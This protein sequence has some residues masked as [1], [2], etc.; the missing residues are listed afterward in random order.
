MLRALDRAVGAHV[1][2]ASP[3]L[4]PLLFGTV[5]TLT[6][7]GL[8]GSAKA[9][10]PQSCP[11]YSKC[12]EVSYARVEA[13]D[14]DAARVRQE[15]ATQEAQGLAQ[16]RKPGLTT[17]QQSEILG[18]LIIHDTSLSPFGN[19]ACA[20]CH[21]LETGFTGGISIFNQENVAYPGS[22]VYRSGPRKPMSYA[23]A[24]FAPLLHYDPAAQDFVGGDFWDMR[25]TGHKTGN[26]AGDQA[27]DPP[28][29]AADWGCR[30]PLA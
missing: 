8:A 3:R 5:I 11:G 25:A 22:V 2:A 26:P 15:I 30:M 6:V 23:Y 17:G 9:G 12:P 28:V 18:K 16:M 13:T 21:I 4:S 14:Q 24:P 20:S 27:Q 7:A 10:T 1:L 19:R 29:D